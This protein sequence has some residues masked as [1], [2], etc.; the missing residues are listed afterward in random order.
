MAHLVETMAYTGERPWHKLGV[1][2]PAGLTPAEIAVLA[3]LDWPVEKRSL[4]AVGDN[5]EVSDVTENFALVRTTDGRVLD[6]VGSR[7]TPT[8]NLDAL[9]FFKRF[10]ESGDM[11]MDTAGSLAG[12]R[13]IWGLASICDGF[14]LRGGD[15]VK[16]YLL[17][18]SPHIQGEAFTVK[19][20]AV[21][22]VCYNTLTS[23]LRGTGPAFRMS[24]LY[25]FDADRKDA[26][27]EVLGLATAQLR[28][29]ESKA[30]VLS[31]AHAEHQRV[32][33]YVAQ[34]SGS[35]VL[36]AV[37]ETEAAAC[38]PA[39][40]AVIT[41]TE[42]DTSL[43]G[44]RET[45]LNKA[46]KTILDAILSAPG[47]DLASARGTWWGALNGVT[48]AADHQ[49]GRTEDS[50]LT[51]AWFGKRAQLKSAAL[52]LAVQYAEVGRN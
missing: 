23:A 12:G 43:R 9:D 5:G 3:G 30:K 33:E 15:E 44:F 4:F 36:D 22:V 38:M 1:P 40:D 51:S 28:D 10:T 50:R 20:T 49:F 11:T 35:K 16:G 6:V 17:L 42:A 8:Q 47:S 27:C 45:D 21:R 46:G 26:A 48:Y 32:V 7:Y 19:L 2:V 37:I 39:L 13:R 25:T 18:C 34:L 41:A 24:H 14:T 31:S 29:M 52:D